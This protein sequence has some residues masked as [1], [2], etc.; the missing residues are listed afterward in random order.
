MPDFDK[1]GCCALGA[2][3]AALPCCLHRCS[4]LWSQFQLCHT[5]WTTL[6]KDVMITSIDLHRPALCLP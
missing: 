5:L 3:S 4:L 2:F 6:Q 1:F